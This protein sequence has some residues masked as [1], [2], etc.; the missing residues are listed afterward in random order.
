MILLYF[1][2]SFISKC[3]IMCTRN[4]SD[5]IHQTS[6]IFHLF[7][8][9]CGA[10]LCIELNNWVFKKAADIN[11]LFWAI[12][13]HNG[14]HTSL[15][16]MTLNRSDVCNKRQIPHFALLLNFQDVKHTHLCRT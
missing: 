12:I 4:N 3:Y 10:Y 11:S 8:I 7:V 6:D 15:I 9:L 1:L 13:N 2:V 5:I 14:H 16:L